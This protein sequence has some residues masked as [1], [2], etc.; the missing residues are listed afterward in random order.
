M[1]P[2]GLDPGLNT[3]PIVFQVQ[4]PDPVRERFRQS[5]VLNNDVQLKL[6]AEI[7]RIV[8]TQLFPTINDNT[9]ADAQLRAR[10]ASAFQRATPALQA[11]VDDALANAIKSTAAWKDYRLDSGKEMARIGVTLTFVAI[12]AGLSPPTA[13][14]S[15]AFMIVSLVR[16]LTDATKKFSEAYRTAEESRARLLAE[17]ARL[18]AAYEKGGAVGRASQLGGA[19]LHA[20]TIGK[21]AATFNSDPLPGFT[22]IKTELNAYKGKLGHLGSR[23]EQLGRR[24]YELLDLIEQYQGAVGAANTP[25]LE[26]LRRDVAALLEDGVKSRWFRGKAT[27]SGAWERCQSGMA[28]LVNVEAQFKALKALEGREKSVVIADRILT[29]LT[30]LS[31]TLAGYNG[32]LGLHDRS[33]EAIQHALHVS[34]EGHVSAGCQSASK[35]DPL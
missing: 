30:N 31:V 10:V 1:Q 25:R 9:R 4:M 6:A 22:R 32:P 7:R 24:L 19:V 3:I 35:R 27:I 18:K 21:M 5:P 12:A 23:A 33:A 2:E 28:E 34:H 16:G 17:I 14:V 15:I 29:L 8:Q 11:I 13:G 26:R 20:L